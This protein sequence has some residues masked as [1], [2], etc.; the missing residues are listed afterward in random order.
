MFDNKFIE[1]DWTKLLG[2][3]RRFKLTSFD[4][5]LEVP[6]WDKW[7]REQREYWGADSEKGLARFHN[8]F[9]TS[10]P[11]GELIKYARKGLAEYTEYIKKWNGVFIPGDEV[12]LMSYLPGK[13]HILLATNTQGNTKLED[14]KDLELWLYEEVTGLL[15]KHVGFMCL[16]YTSGTLIVPKGSIENQM[17]ERAGQKKVC[18]KKIDTK[19]I[20]YRDGKL[21]IDDAVFD[22]LGN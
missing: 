4:Q 7:Y 14:H 2:R 16:G 5:K 22:R 13:P 1:V 20:D 12:S 15:K 19:K 11:E 8:F 10:D 6:T 17:G 21:V 9:G 3:D 18:H